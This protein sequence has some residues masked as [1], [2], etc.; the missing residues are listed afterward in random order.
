M[1]LS[2]KQLEVFSGLVCALALIAVVYI[3]P[4]QSSYLIPIIIAIVGGIAGIETGR[5][6]EKKKNQ[7]A[8]GMDTNDEYAERARRRE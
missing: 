1:N 6:H 5:R 7:P 8:A 3:D 2:D 4:S